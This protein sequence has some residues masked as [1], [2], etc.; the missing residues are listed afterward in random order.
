VN[1]GASPVVQ[2]SSY[3]FPLVLG[4]IRGYV[5]GQTGPLGDFQVEHGTER[6]TVLILDTR[7]L[8]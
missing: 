7:T 6:L 8:F 2:T 3:W 5:G 1:K 4:L